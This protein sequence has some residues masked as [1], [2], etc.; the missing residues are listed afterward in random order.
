MD[1]FAKDENNAGTKM[2]I[3]VKDGKDISEFSIF[4]ESE[5]LLAPNSVF[6]VKSIISEDMKTLLKLAA[7]VD[8]I[9]LVQE[10]TPNDT[11]IKLPS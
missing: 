2:I 6:K 4:D 7:N 1:D 9:H 3:E 5:V 11:I 8:V 10:L